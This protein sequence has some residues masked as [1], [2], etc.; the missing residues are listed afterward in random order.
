M[1]FDQDLCE[2]CSWG[3][4]QQN[5]SIGQD[6]GLEPVRRQAIIWANDGRL[7]THICITWCQWVKGQHYELLYNLGNTEK[8]L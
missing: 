6:N 7:P 2:V 3:S 1:N 8:S 4:N 5:P